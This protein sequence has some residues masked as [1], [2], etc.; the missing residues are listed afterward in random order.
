MNLRGLQE[1]RRGAQALLRAF[2]NVNSMYR[3]VVKC[4]VCSEWSACWL[5]RDKRSKYVPLQE[6]GEYEENKKTADAESKRV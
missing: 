2:C 3:L 6:N 5:H 4:N 1:T